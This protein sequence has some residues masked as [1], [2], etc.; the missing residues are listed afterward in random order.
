MLETIK[1]NVLLPLTSRLGS[2]VAGFLVPYGVH[3][4]SAE[5][6]AIGV[7]GVGL[8]SIDLVASWLN[9]RASGQ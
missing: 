7:I 6:L 9:R 8:V 4:E 2:M 1:R 3:S 5:M